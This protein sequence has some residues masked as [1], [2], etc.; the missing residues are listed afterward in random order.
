[1]GGGGGLGGGGG[2]LGGG[3]LG[4]GGLGGGGWGGG[5]RVWDSGLAFRYLRF[6][7]KELGTPDSLT[8]SKIETSRIPNF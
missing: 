7:V 5:F 6:R 8:A 1:M 4:G 2:G 3:G